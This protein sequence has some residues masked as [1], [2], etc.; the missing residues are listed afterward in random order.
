MRRSID[1]NS[2]F[3]GDGKEMELYESLLDQELAKTMA[4]NGS[5][6]LAKVLYNQLKRADEALQHQEQAQGGQGENPIWP[7]KARLSSRF[8]WR[9]DPIS[10][11]RR[12]HQGIDLAASQGTTVRAALAGRVLKSGTNGKYGNVVVVNH[13]QGLTT[14]YAH[15][16]KNLVKAGDL[17]QAGMPLAEVG[18]TGRST[19][20]HLHFEVR[21]HNRHLDPLG[22]L[23]GERD[24]V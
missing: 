5:N 22:F 18:S 12:F 9:K 15:N 4:G 13:G 16:S 1:R 20:P 6:S 2:L 19:G 14:L 10:G 23:K 8:G 21:R 7:L 3:H 17:V 24:P 11:E